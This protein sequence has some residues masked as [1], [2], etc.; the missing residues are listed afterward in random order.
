MKRCSCWEVATVAF[1]LF[2]SVLAIGA[3]D[4]HAG[5][6][7]GRDSF[8][9]SNEPG[10]CFAMAAFSRWYFLTNEGG[11]P[12]RGVCSRRTQRRIAREL[13]NFYSKRLVRIQAEYCNRYS[14]DPTESF[15]RFIL[16]VMMG[17][18][19]IVLLMNRSSRGAVL[20]AVL[21]Y[22]WLPE[23][24]Y[25]K[26]YDPNYCNQARIIDLDRMEYQS[27]DIA[28]N[29]FCFPEIFNN[30]NGLVRKMRQ[31]YNRH[32]AKRAAYRAR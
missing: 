30:H 8:S 14:G 21:A 2:G 25:L 20:H 13:Q 15:R 23:H 22:E 7:I 9:V 3:Q 31:L 29:A 5:F 17:E 32:M 11:P 24:N 18:P 27:L 4:S 19:R 12:L 10:H 1:V 28:Y 6:N 16:G 26:V